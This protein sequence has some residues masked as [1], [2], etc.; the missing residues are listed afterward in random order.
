MF[1]QRINLGPAKRRFVPE[2][3]LLAY[4]QELPSFRDVRRAVNIGSKDGSKSLVSL[5]FTTA[6]TKFRGK[7]LKKFIGFGISLQRECKT[8]PGERRT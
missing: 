2:T 8:S 7:K 5:Y 4:L 6:I 1:S 3:V